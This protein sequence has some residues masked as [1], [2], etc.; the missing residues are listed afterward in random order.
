MSMQTDC[1]YG[2]GFQIKIKP[3]QLQKF[4]Q[5]HKESIEQIK[6]TESVLDCLDLD[7]DAFENAF[8]D[9]EYY[10][11][12]GFGYSLTTI[13]ADI[14]SVETGLPIAYYPPAEDDDRESILYERAYP[15]E[16]NDKEKN[17]TKDEI[18]AIFEK[19]INELDPNIK[20]D[21]DIG[22]EYYG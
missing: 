13:I 1:I 20:V 9:F 15:W 14:M 6:G 5:D 22:L 17:L 19:Y 11:N 18:I 8:L 12:N 21:D 4:L 16:M 3:D 10:P 7:K 2:I